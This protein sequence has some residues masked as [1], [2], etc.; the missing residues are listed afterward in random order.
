[1]GDPYATVNVANGYFN[2]AA[3]AAVPDTG[4]IETC[5]GTT[6]RNYLIGPGYKNL[7]FSAFKNFKMGERFTTQFRAGFFNLTNT[8]QFAQPDASLTDGN[9]GKLPSTRL[10]S[11]REIQFALRIMF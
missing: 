7:D 5:G 10:G 3:F 2:P 11:E 8:P 1:M 9:F 4:G 6:P